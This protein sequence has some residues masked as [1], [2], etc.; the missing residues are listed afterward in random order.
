MQYLRPG[1]DLPYKVLAHQVLIVEDDPAIRAGLKLLL[2]RHGRAEVLTA[3]TLAEARQCLTTAAPSHAIIDLNLP[4][5]LGTDL[6]REMRTQG[7]PTRVM[8]LTAS[9]DPSLPERA[10]QLGAEGVLRKPPDWQQL[11]VWTTTPPMEL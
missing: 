5:G 1:A 6:L 3:A 11:A 10:K 2:L 4:D 9:A 8:L 7:L